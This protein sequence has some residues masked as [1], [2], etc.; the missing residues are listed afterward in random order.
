MQRAVKSVIQKIVPFCRWSALVKFVTSDGAHPEFESRRVE[1]KGHIFE[2]SK[3]I[4]KDKGNRLLRF[5]KDYK[6]ISDDVKRVEM[7]MH[8]HNLVPLFELSDPKIVTRD[9]KYLHD[10]HTNSMKQEALKILGDV[11]DLIYYE[12]NGSPLIS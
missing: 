12:I 6:D 8:E 10:A 1:L 2:L 4:F 9:Y 3:H 5:P 11:G 7:K